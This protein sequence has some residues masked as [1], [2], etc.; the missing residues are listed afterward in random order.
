MIKNKSI[1]FLLILVI[2]SLLLVSCNLSKSPVEPVIEEPVV[3]ISL[4]TKRDT[5]GLGDTLHLTIHNNTKNYSSII[6][7]LRRASITFNNHFTDTTIS[8]VYDW[9]SEYNISLSLV[10]GDS[11]IKKIERKITVLPHYFSLHFSVGMIWKYSYKYY[12]SYPPTG[13]SIS[14]NGIHTWEILSSEINNSD[15]IYAVRQIRDDIKIDNGVSKTIKDTTMTKFTVSPTKI[16]I[17]WQLY[18]GIVTFS[19]SN[20][21]VVYRLPIKPSDYVSI[22]DKVGPLGYYYYRS[23]SH[24]LELKQ[25]FALIDFYKPK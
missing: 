11:V 4:T 14:Q 13:T 22:D 15:T 16:D 9:S 17:N 1:Y 25:E 12:D 8:F 21:S 3:D 19:F 5:I 6:L 23:G 10:D 18:G 7:D 24:G 20:N 2:T